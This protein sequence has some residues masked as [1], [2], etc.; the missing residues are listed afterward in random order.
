MPKMY[1]VTPRRPRFNALFYGD[2]GSG[3]TTLAASAQDS[4]AMADVVFYNV[5]GGL[6][7][8]AHRG[9]I[10]AIDIS[11]CDELDHE[12][13][14]LKSREDEYR[15]VK[16]V[17]IDSGTELQTMNLQEIVR[18][19]MT[20]GS[21]KSGKRRDSEDEIW[22]DDYGKSTAYL[23]RIY[24]QFKD[25][26]HNVIVTALAKYTYPKSQIDLGRSEAQ[27][28]A[29]GVEPLVV[30]PS[31]TQKVAE[32]LMGY[33][34][35][36]W[37]TFYDQEDDTYKVLTKS[38]GPYRAK[39]RGPHFQKALGDVVKQPSLADIYTLYV[40]TESR[41]AAAVTP[42]KKKS[43]AVATTSSNTRNS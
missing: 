12:F 22:Q 25:L 21:S 27:A 43:R 28:R 24:R 14:K 3:K 37:Y 4:P 23:R 30:L 39:T 42:A 6:L 40:E 16:T 8:I 38:S 35:F 7:S 18:S 13:W 5:E 10:R 19:A 34:D 26:P 15:T 9:D 17:V 2:P 36:V 20:K 31:M 1:T 33:M 41:R 32:S 29:M 11:A